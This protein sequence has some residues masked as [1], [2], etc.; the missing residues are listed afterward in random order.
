M[1]PRLHALI[2]V[3]AV[4]APNAILI[5]CA[6]QRQATPTTLDPSPAPIA[7]E[8]APSLEI[9]QGSYGQSQR[10]RYNR[11]YADPA[12]H[13]SEPNEFMMTCLDWIEQIR[14]RETNK[15]TLEAA[16]RGTALDIAMGEG[17][18]TIALAQRGY[19][20]AGFDV[21]DVGVNKARQ[22]AA[23]LGLDIDARVQWF[24]EFD[25]GIEQWDVMVMTY[26]SLDNKG[27]KTVTD[28]IKPRGYFI[29]ERSGGD[30]YN[31]FLRQLPLTSWEILVYQQNNGPRDWANSASNPGPGMRTQVLARKR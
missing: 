13:T 23:E 2:V 19:H 17:R 31:T 5:S 7:F 12:R 16:S 25:F 30:I 6:P 22:R 4:L 14:M 11:I 15:Q 18:N 9:E 8:P 10:D 26:F 24:H 1:R 21:S 3:A 27:M 28:S 29:I 20:A